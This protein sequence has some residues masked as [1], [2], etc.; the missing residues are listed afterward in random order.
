MSKLKAQNIDFGQDFWKGDRKASGR[1]IDGLRGQNI[2]FNSK[3]I[4]PTIGLDAVV[5]HKSTDIR[6][7]SYLSAQR[8]YRLGT[9]FVRQLMNYNGEVRMGHKIGATYNL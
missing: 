9:H 7:K 6:L 8:L 2:P 3:I 5:S 4:D 1:S